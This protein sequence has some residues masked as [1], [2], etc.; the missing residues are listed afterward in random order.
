MTNENEESPLLRVRV[1]D[2]PAHGATVRVDGRLTIGRAGGSDVQLVHDGISRQ[3]AQIITDDQGRHVLVDLD[4]SNGTFVDG[5]RIRRYVLTPGTVF[6]IMKIK[7]VYERFVDA[8]VSED[9]GVFA[10]QPVDRRVLKPTIDYVALDLPRPVTRVAEPDAPVPRKR[11]RSSGAVVQSLGADRHRVVATRTNGSVYEHSLIDDIVE[12]R[13]L[14]AHRL[15][16]DTPSD[17]QRER[18]EQLRGRLARPDERHPARRC[19]ERFSCH[20]PAKLR[21]A[22]GHELSIAVLDLGVDGARVRAYDHELSHG[23][24][25]WLAIH[26]VTRGRPQTVVFTGRVEWT[27]EH[28][29]GLSF[30][31]APGWEQQGSRPRTPTPVMETPTIKR[32]RRPPSGGV[33]LGRVTPRV[34][35]R[36]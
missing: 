19:F 14:R 35:A 23:E 5:R 10:V 1:L 27:R 16:G 8:P 2:G 4:S 30:S 24:I 21:F 34:H 18:L 12:L 36:S 7:L 20:F 26:L 6:K 17:G 13:A 33:V 22:S 3:H 15:R 25:V 9:S 32:R 31:G 28:H 11:P 29:I